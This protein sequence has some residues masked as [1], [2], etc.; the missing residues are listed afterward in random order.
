M[1]RLYRVC[2]LTA[3]TLAILSVTSHVY[4]DEEADLLAAVKSYFRAEV[5]DNPRQV[6]E[7]IAPSSVFK[8][9][10]TYAMYLEMVKDNPLTVKR[11]SVQKV[12]KIIEG[13]DKDTMPRVE[14]LGLVKVRVTLTDAGGKETEHTNVLTFLKE[15]GRWYKG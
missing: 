7:M 4:A 3:V 10:F 11:Y 13:P 9:R 14:K 15:G 6:W 2:L 8:K 1:I 5:A 12:V